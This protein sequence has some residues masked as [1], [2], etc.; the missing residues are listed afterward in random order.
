MNNVEWKAFY[1]DELFSI[2]RGNAKDIGNKMEGGNISLISAIDSNNG[3]SK[4]ITPSNKE[5]IYKNVYTV[6]NNGNG[7]CLAYF[8]PYSFIATSDVTILKPKFD[9]LIDLDVAHFIITMIQQ[10]KSKYNYGYKMS[11]DRMKKQAILLPSINNQPDY[12]FMKN[13]IMKI[14]ENKTAKYIEFAKN[15][16]NHISIGGGSNLIVELSD[17]IWKDILINRLFTT[18]IRGKRLTKA[19][20]VQGDTPYVSSSSLCNGVDNFIGN[21]TRV[22]KFSDCLSLANSGSVGSCFYHPYEFI[23]SDHVTQ[24]KNEK[25]S[26]ASYLFLSVLL[27]RFNEKYNFNREISDERISRE[28]ILVPVKNDDSFD[29]NYMEKIVKLLELK[30][31]KRYLNYKGAN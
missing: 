28:K 21:K 7:V 23:A 12:A 26:E 5:T 24:L 2:K 13:Y 14:R 17:N 30:L 16:I 25:F 9:E 18:C 3:L 8:H 22:R 11:N 31:Y 20:Q 4:I 10:Q 15:K 6:N 29:D 27:K 1:I 19:N